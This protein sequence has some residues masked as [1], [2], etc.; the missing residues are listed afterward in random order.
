MKGKH[1]CIHHKVNP[2][3]LWTS[4]SWESRL[5]LEIYL[6]VEWEFTQS[7]EVIQGEI[8]GVWCLATCWHHSRRNMGEEVVQHRKRCSFRPPILRVWSRLWLRILEIGGKG[9]KRLNFINFI[10]LS[11]TFSLDLQDHTVCYQTSL[12]NMKHVHTKCICNILLVIRNQ[13]SFN[14]V[15]QSTSRGETDKGCDW[16]GQINAL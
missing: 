13:I 6:M 16:G 7:G 2:L 12:L 11:S 15:I 5:F 10:L 9:V 14:L 4:L 1:K 3:V 8:R